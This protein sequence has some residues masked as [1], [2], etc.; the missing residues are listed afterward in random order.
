METAQRPTL[1]D[2]LNKCGIFTHGTLL[3]NEK[4][5]TNN[6]HNSSINLKNGLLS[7]ISLL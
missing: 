1:G 4:E 7:K 5:Q 3:S 6:M 2:L